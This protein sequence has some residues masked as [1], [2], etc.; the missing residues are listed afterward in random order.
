V[1][2]ICGVCGALGTACDS[3]RRREPLGT[4][5]SATPQSA[6]AA[7]AP[8]VPARVAAIGNTTLLPP[9]LRRAMEAEKAQ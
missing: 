1:I 3:G 7:K 2:A 4:A 6:P 8:P 9:D 5:N